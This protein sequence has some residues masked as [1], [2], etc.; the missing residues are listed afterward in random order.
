MRKIEFPNIKDENFILKSFSFLSFHDNFTNT[1][2][3]P[4]YE[5]YVG[6]DVLCNERSATH[7]DGKNY[8]VLFPQCW[9]FRI[10][11]QIR[12][13][14]EIHFVKNLLRPKL[15]QLISHKIWVA[16]NVL[17]FSQCVFVLGIKN[18]FFSL[19]E[20]FW[21]IPLLFPYYA[22][23]ELGYTNIAILWEYVLLYCY[24][25]ISW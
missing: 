24:L 15:S 2:K 7:F 5:K 6:D 23:C 3:K 10:F 9:N 20:P 22:F 16:E 21:A 13:L 18:T 25:H 1:R 4:L 17:R 12:I 11:L 14:R 8:L 19:F